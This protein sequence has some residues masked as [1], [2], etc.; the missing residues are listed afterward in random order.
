[1]TG[2]IIAAIIAV[3]VALIAAGAGV[4]FALYAAGFFN[5][6]GGKKGSPNAVSKDVLAKKLLALNDQTKTYHIVKGED[7]DLLAE[8]K[9]VDAS[10]YGIFNKSGLK[11]AYR[12]R[13]LLDETRHSVR[14]YEELGSVSWSAGAAGLIPGVHYQK[15]QFGGRVLFKK[16]WGVGYGGKQLAPLEVGKVYD[17]KFDID[18]ISA[19]IITAVKENGW[20]WVPVTA[21]RLATYPKS[22]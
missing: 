12:A 3:V 20:E 21:R 5:Y 8:W 19:P 22:P 11:E 9:I 17:Y 1:M 14:C 6:L 10:W 2:M 15:T 13:L 4:F 7:S 16:E 18:E